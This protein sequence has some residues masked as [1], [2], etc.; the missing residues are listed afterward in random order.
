MERDN[1]IHKIMN[2]IGVQTFPKKGNLDSVRSFVVLRMYVRDEKNKKKKKKKKEENFASK[3][4][5]SSVVE[6][7][8]GTTRNLVRIF[9]ALNESAFRLANKYIFVSPFL[10]R[11]LFTKKEIHTYVQ[12]TGIFP[13]LSL[14]INNARA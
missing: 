9:S 11:K 10:A 6:G 2:A 5:F 14:S 13:F 1:K 3:A 4:Q 7:L 12:R 8:I